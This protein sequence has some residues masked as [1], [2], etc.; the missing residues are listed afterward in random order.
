[1][2][3]SFV[4]FSV[5]LS[6][7]AVTFA[8]DEK[9]ESKP[10]EPEAVKLD[11]KVSFEKDILDVIELNCVACH[12]EG[13]AESRLV[14]EDVPAMIKG[15]K[16]GAG[17]VP[18]KPDES[19]VYLVAARKKQ[20]HMPPLPNKVEAAS[21]TPRELG[22]FRQW[23]IEGAVSDS[24][25]SVET[26]NWQPIPAGMKSTYA[27]A[28]SPW[29]D[30]VAAS[31][32]NQLSV[33]N[34][35]TGEEARLVDPAL[36]GLKFN[37]Q[38]MYPNGAAHRDFVHSVAFHPN[39]RLIAS[40]GYRVV[41]LWERPENV[42]SLSVGIGAVANDV[43]VSVEKG[44]A[45]F[46]T[47][48]NSVLVRSLK[49]GAEIKK[50]DGHTGS[51]NGVA[52]TADGTSVVS[53]S[54]DQTVRIWSLESGAETRQIKTPSPIHDVCVSVDGK[55]IATA[56]EDKVIRI[57]SF[58][59]PE[60]EQPE[61]EKPVRELKG[62][63][64]AVTSLAQV[65][66]NADQIISG[67]AD[68]TLRVWQLSNGQNVRSMNH[69]GPIV[70]VASR[71]DGQAFASVSS[72]NTA[73]LWTASNG[74]QIAEMR[75]HLTAQHEE[76]T[77]KE[78]AD[79]AKQLVA[80]A[81]AAQK[82]AEKNAKERADALKK[83]G[84]EKDKQTKAVEEQKPK[85]A[86]AQKKAD[87][88][89][90]AVDTAQKAVDD[91]KTKS[92]AAAK[93]SADKADDQ[94]LKKA[95]TDAANALK[96]AEAELKKKTDALKAPT[97]ELKKQSDELKKREEALKSGTRSLELATKADAKAKQD[98]EAAK[99]AH[100]KTQEEQKARDE[101]YKK[102]QESTKAA[103]APLT[104][105]AFSSD[106]TR[107]AT[108]AENGT[109]TLWSAASGK[110]LDVLTGSG[111]PVRTLAFAAGSQLVSAGDDQK[112]T[113]WDANPAWQLVAQLGPSKDDPMNTGTSR[114]EFR[115]LALT[116]S[117]DG[118][119][120][121]TGGGEPSRSGELLLWDVEK[122]ELAREVA[123]AHS[124][125]V[126]GIQFSR[127]GS[128]IVSGAADKFVKIHNVADATH[129]R[130]FEGH[131]HHVMDVSWKADGSRLVSAG[132][133]N[134]IKVWNVET[135][136][137]VRT[138]S[139]YAKQVTSIEFVGVGGNTISCGGDKTVRLHTAENGRNY[140]NFSGATDFMYAADASRDESVVVSG[141]ED[142]I[143]RVWNGTNGQVIR[144]FEVPAPPE[145]VQASN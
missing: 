133:D 46:A 128:Q 20:P 135:G 112:A 5:A 13:G 27:L 121:A 22:L 106:G 102:S 78:E 58:A 100:A 43:A 12:Y 79:V 118:K 113:I 108:A 9:P 139:N 62:H 33:F 21:L 68:S 81:D 136:E 89:Q 73:K 104:A 19:L 50:L 60:G 87:E 141:G 10:I 101:A 48:Q 83:A 34:L 25:D 127:D 23:I 29:G 74:K 42:Q 126:F 116:F 37:D 107:L 105:V 35:Q 145:N 17:I 132:A 18:G 28:L 137:Q 57:W 53:G 3:R 49:D 138:I 56:H 26:V 90:A 2:I 59:A 51:V 117:P 124:D 109:I 11:R 77:S 24:E 93:A 115:V 120:L 30:Q 1:M 64:G 47:Q 75:G 91:A 95:A 8:A 70:D 129:V 130:S 31:R 52:L 99:A 85:V 54:A 66:G 44:L 144:N 110:A 103:E 76:A 63:G 123:D 98:V 88:A 61:G 143:I 122:R 6:L 4:A 38:A 134:A 65:G 86:E 32:A 111:S 15:G 80:L 92:E 94:E 7:S 142:G 41:K 67:S 125:T 39:G 96:A 40:G 84:E 119:L 36:G 71:P 69:G 55:L 72:N 97:D 114:F 131:T 45:A 140:R 14:L 82:A 16:R